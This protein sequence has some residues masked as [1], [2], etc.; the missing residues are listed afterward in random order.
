MPHRS[1]HGA[2]CDPRLAL[3]AADPPDNKTKS[4]NRAV[5]AAPARLK[6]T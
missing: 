2:G 3:P 5:P 4:H 6:G 1:E